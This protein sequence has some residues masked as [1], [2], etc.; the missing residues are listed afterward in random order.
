MDEIL[1]LLL[2]E[3]GAYLLIAVMLFLVWRIA[4]TLKGWGDKVLDEAIAASKTR[5]AA[6]ESM[7]VRMH[8]HEVHQ[9]KL[10]GQT[11]ERVSE[12]AKETRHDLRAAIEVGVGR[13]EGTMEAQADR[14]LERM[15]GTKGIQ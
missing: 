6:V 13:T 1:K 11:V 10:H 2:K 4:P 12:A 7:L 14:I 5:T 15:N 9:T 3:G 8:E